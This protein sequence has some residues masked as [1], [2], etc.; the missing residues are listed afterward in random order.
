MSIL[1]RPNFTYN[2][3]YL[4]VDNVV[5]NDIYNTSS[6]YPDIDSVLLIRTVYDGSYLQFDLHM[7][8]KLHQ[9]KIKGNGTID[10]KIISSYHWDNNLISD[11][12]ELLFSL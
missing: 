6:G 2:W 7:E 11:V 10:Y 8:P 1:I 9:M 12:E 5:I 4:E 3:F